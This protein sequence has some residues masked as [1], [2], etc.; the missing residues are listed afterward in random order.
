MFLR[1]FITNI[2][3]GL[4]SKKYIF[5]TM[6]FPLALGT[7]FYFAF[8]QIYASEQ[9]KA[10]PVALIVEGNP[11][12]SPFLSAMS[13]FTYNDGTA[14][15]EVKDVKD[16][17]EAEQLLKDDDIKGIITVN[18]M[19]ASLVIAENGTQQS[20]LTS[21]LSSYQSRKDVLMSLMTSDTFDP[22]KSA[23]IQEMI[24]ESREYVDAGG[25]AGDNKD[26]YVTYFYNLIAM[27]SMM[28][29][30]ATSSSVVHARA[31]QSDEG[32][33]IDISPVKK[34]VLELAQFLAFAV[35][36]LGITTIA[37]TYYTQ[38]LGIRFGGNTALIYL[39][40]YMANLLGSSLGFLVGHIG[41]A[42]EN[43]KEN[44]LLIITLGGGFM[45]GL[46][47][48]D[49]KVIMEEKFPLFNRI[50]PSAVITDA[51]YSLNI[52]GTGAR[53]YRSAAYMIILTLVFVTVGLFLSRRK[54][55]AS[56]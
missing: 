32:I 48:G 19:D 17:A 51:F 53:Y 11:E 12:E 36:Q 46:M 45:A 30:M 27:I 47:Y 33:R 42:S 21:I 40:S 26:P 3:I 4:R 37:L 18:G 23:E 1:I 41:N 25:M 44:I 56:L 20:V 55:Y 43:T 9:S 14:L 24:S 8:G 7:L 50:N 34:P 29:A 52:F 49:M 6:A 54:Q 22:E 31:N 13:Q 38:I 39:T 35:L 28:G 16:K 5:W 2:K 10:I 15:L